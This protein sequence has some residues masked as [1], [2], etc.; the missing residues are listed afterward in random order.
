VQRLVPHLLIGIVAGT[1][2]ALPAVGQT[3]G[4]AGQP[5]DWTG[6]VPAGGKLRIADVHGDIRVTAATGDKVVVHGDV[7]SRG[8]HSSTIAFDV[9][10]EGNVVAICARWADGPACTTHGLHDD[11]D[12]N[13]GESASA[14]F[15]VQLPRGVRLD[16][17]TGNGRVDISG[18][19]SDVGA[20][21][22]NGAVRVSG[23]TGTVTAS[24]GN[25][26]VIV[27]GAGGAVSASTGN[28]VVRAYTNAGPV[29]ASTGNGDIDVRMQTLTGRSD[30][31]FSTGNGE[32]TVAVPANYSADVD[33]ETGHGTI[34]S[35]FPMQVSGRIDPSRLH[36]VIGAGG[37]R[38]KL[39]SGNG[40]L[41][42]R[43]L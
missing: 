42:L 8:R 32:V 27:E 4:S 2:S 29:N 6:Q 31:T 34:R 7:R 11:S 22:G 36:A 24:S 41:V 5:F 30:M 14:D 18:T 17:G 40:D 10:S 33:A 21:S 35:D 20:S 37:G 13:E 9:V 15:T 38:L 3:G 1:V 25:G 16:A 43:K 19:G 28:G 39:T 26:E 12:E 23:A